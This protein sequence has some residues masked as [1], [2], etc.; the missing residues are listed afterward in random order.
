MY[1]AIIM[2]DI[3]HV[4]LMHVVA[5]YTTFFYGNITARHFLLHIHRQNE[6]YIH[7]YVI[8]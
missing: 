8:L 4:A 6:S 2:V 5:N 7:V 3:A 1:I